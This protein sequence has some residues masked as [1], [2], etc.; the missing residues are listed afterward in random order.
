VNSENAQ[1]K[2]DFYQTL[3]TVLVNLSIILS[4]IMP[5]L[6]DIIYTNLTG[7]ESVHLSSW[8]E[9]S[10]KSNSKLMEEMSLVRRIIEVGHRVRKENKLKNRQPLA[11]ATIKL[12]VKNNLDVYSDLIKGELNVKKINIEIL[13]NKILNDKEIDVTYDT[14]LTPELILEGKVRDLIRE[15]QGMRKEQGKK[16]SEFI[17]LVVPQEFKDYGDFFKKRVMAKSVEFGDKLLIR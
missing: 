2:A 6:S 10:E 3:Y 1:D 13:D 9:I 16:T 15:I 14:K 8:P 5:F 11:S 12:A 7:D 17:E 4:P